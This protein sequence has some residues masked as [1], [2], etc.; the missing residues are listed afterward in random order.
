MPG[1]ITNYPKESVRE[2][3]NTKSADLI[4]AW[5]QKE[6]KV[7]VERWVYQTALVITRYSTGEVVKTGVDKNG[8]DIL[9]MQNYRLAQ[10]EADICACNKGLSEI[11]WLHDSA[12]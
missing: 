5:M 9:T 2:G 8:K 4:Q 1:P 3:L 6:M 12:P 7:T 11:L 10:L